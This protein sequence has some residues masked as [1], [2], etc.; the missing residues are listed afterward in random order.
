MFEK[1]DYQGLRR[2]LD[3]HHA[4][5][6]AFE[7]THPGGAAPAR[8]LGLPIE[9]VASACGFGSAASLRAH[10][11]KQTGTSPTAYRQAFAGSALS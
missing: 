1:I 2:L 10:F 6:M 4:A 8:E 3:R 7:S 5:P 9:D 11:R